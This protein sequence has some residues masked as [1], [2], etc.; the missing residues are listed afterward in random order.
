MKPG[1]GGS[2]QPAGSLDTALKHARQLLDS[3]PA[4]AA[5]QAIEILKVC[6]R[7]PEARLIA[8]AARRLVSDTVGSVETLRALTADLPEWGLAHHELG[9]ALAQVGRGDEALVA[10]EQAVTLEPNMADAWRALADHLT[11]IGD[12]AAADAAYARQIKAAAHD[13]RLLPA[14]AALCEGRIPIAERLLRNHLKRMPTDVAAIRMLAEVAARIGRYHDAELLLSRALELAPGFAA[15]RQNYALVLHRQ[16]KASD[17]LREVERLLAEDPNHPSYRNLK[18]VV[19]GTI[20]E[21]EHSIAIYAGLIAQYSQQPKI[22]I[23]YGHAL[24]TAGRQAD[25]VAAYRRTLEL[26]PTMGEAYWSLA[27]LKTFRFESTDIDAMRSQLAHPHLSDEDRCFFEFA[28]GKALE[29]AGDYAQ[30]LEYYERGNRRRRAQVSY[31]PDELTDLVRRSRQLLDQRFF[32]QRRGYGAAAP[33]PIFIVGL[34]RAGSTLLEQILAS[35]SAIEGTMELPDLMAIAR[36]LAGPVRPDALPPYPH[37]LANL[38]AEACR[39]LGEQYLARTRIHRKRGAPFFIDKM[40]NNF[41]HIGLIQLALPSARIIDAR[42]HPL[43]CCLSAFKQHFARGQNFSYTFEELGRYYRDYVDLMAHFDAVL[44]GRV[45][46][47]NYEALIEN[48]EAEVRRLLHYCG[49]PFEEQC[50]RF[51]ENARAVRTAS[52]EQ[53]RQPLFRDGLTHWRHYEAHLEP[54]RAA[55]GPVLASHRGAPDLSSTTAWEEKE[56][57]V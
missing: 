2:S 6:P 25:A 3:R 20:G 39:A 7:H 53:V 27:N 23:S 40:P 13:S 37:V 42:R 30:S 50:L 49:L 34:P 36:E 19:L 5:E 38:S 51:H 35:H 33:D 26:A 10:F 8:G 48:P 11:A 32:E 24:K 46:R 43:G 41:A 54:L 52:S 47:V 9:L 12:F 14:A 44:P 56:I 29:D 22:W 18:A 16:A 15:A 55:L 17:A 21:Y 57:H 31:D 4:L 28:L 1:T 45:H